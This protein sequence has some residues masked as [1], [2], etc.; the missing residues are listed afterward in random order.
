MSAKLPIRLLL[1]LALV[2]LL[3]VLLL[4]LQLGV[5]LLWVRFC[6]LGAQL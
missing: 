3:L 1:A 5:A 4:L 2:E 6:T